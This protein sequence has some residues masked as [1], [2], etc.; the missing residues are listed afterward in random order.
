MQP[1]LIKKTSSPVCAGMFPQ[2]G[3]TCLDSIAFLE[4]SQQATGTSDGKMRQAKNARKDETHALHC[5][6]A[7]VARRTWRGGGQNLGGRILDSAQV[8]TQPGTL[9]FIRRAYNWVRAIWRASQR[10]VSSTC[11]HHRPS[12]SS[13]ESS[14]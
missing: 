8:A 14:R 9:Q 11:T 2:A 3:S 10:R 7:K 4:C 12:I 13:S 6:P 5:I 1:T